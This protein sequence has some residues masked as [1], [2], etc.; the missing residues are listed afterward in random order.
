MKY[1]LVEVGAGGIDTSIFVGMCLPKQCSDTVITK[2]FDSA[3]KILGLPFEVFS[4]DS[5]T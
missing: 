3:F 5:N 4:L 2:S 1:S